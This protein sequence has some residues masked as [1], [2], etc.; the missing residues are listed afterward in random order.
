[1]KPIVDAPGFLRYALSIPPS[2]SSS[3]PF[4]IKVDGKNGEN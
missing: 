4:G 1:V 2:S 3:F